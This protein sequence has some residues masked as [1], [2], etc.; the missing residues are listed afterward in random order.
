M[1]TTQIRTAQRL[2]AQ[3][4]ETRNRYADFLRAAA[5]LAVVLGH[6]LMAAVWVDGS[7]FH[8]ANVLGRITT[9]QWLTWGFQVMP[10]F[11]LVGGFANAIGWL[12]SGGDY[13]VWLSDRLRRLILPTIPLLVLWTGIGV[14]GP[15]FGLDAELL[16][17]GSQLALIPLWF[18][19]VYVLMVAAT[20]LTLRLWDRFGI[21]GAATLSMA[22]L[23]T[24][25]VRRAGSVHV[26]FANY[27][28][29]WGAIYLLGHGWHAGYF[30]D[31]KQARRLALLAG[32]ILL[33]MTLAGPYH[34][35]MV[36]VPGVEFGNT[37]PPSAALLA[38]GMTQIGLALSIEQPMR[39][40]L[41]RSTPWTATILV[42]GS[43][44]T[45]YVWHM[46]AM[47]LAIG[48]MVLIQFPLLALAPGD[49]G[50][51]QSRPLW[52]AILAICTVPM[53]VG[54]RRFEAGSRVRRQGQGTAAGAV[55]AALGICITFA[56]A[57]AKGLTLAHPAWAAAALI[58]AV[59]VVRWI[60][61]PSG[62]RITPG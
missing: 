1:A 4:P 7:G 22:A 51:W 44:M 55:L 32:T 59:A 19:A 10:I 21:G 8:T 6:W 54:L 52:L 37:A 53:L 12:R 38:L 9:T 5:I 41:S 46:T 45:L 17:S 61:A 56:S 11:F 26:G 2:A 27:V 58:P 30:Q 24:D 15:Q 33:A 20:P 50:W 40:W 23:L 25:V 60:R 39:R 16:R 62:R 48:A 3:T 28:F 36:G 49:A 31:P 57:S 35:S 43:I 42:N 13:A 14:F 29:V 34:I 18:L 47:A